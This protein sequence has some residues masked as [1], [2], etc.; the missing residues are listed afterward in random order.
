MEEIKNDLLEDIHLNGQMFPKLDQLVKGDSRYIKDLR[1]NIKNILKPKALSS[2]EIALTGM[3]LAANLKNEKIQHFFE[4]LADAEEATEEEKAEALACASLLAANNVLYRFRHFV[5][6]DDYQRKPA[7]IRMNIMMKPVLGKELFEL[8]SLAVSAVNGCEA[9]VKSHEQS[10][11]SEGGSEDK[12]WHA[13][14]IAS[15]VN[16]MDRIVH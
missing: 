1:L 15:V 4:T 5:D 11:L 6:K 8:I 7:R 13:I 9:C 3:A 2:K 14:R 10:V 12:I 16:S